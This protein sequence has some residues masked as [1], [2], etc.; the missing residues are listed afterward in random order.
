VSAVPSFVTLA[1]LVPKVWGRDELSCELEAVRRALSL[2]QELAKCAS[3]E[4]MLDAFSIWLEP[5]V[6]HLFLGLMRDSGT[7]A[8]V[9]SS[10]YFKTVGGLEDFAVR[11]RALDL[12][13]DGE[14]IPIEAGMFAMTWSVPAGD[15]AQRIVILR[16]RPLGIRDASIVSHALREMR[17]PLGRAVEFNHLYEQARK[18]SLTGLAN[19]RVLDETL[20][21]VHETARRYERPA[22]LA[23]LDLDNFKKI[24]DVY[25]HEAGDQILS[26]CA[27]AMNQLARS[28]DLI[29]RT[30]GDEFM[31]VLPDTT[32]ANA[33][34]LV[35][36]LRTLIGQLGR[37]YPGVTGFGLSA[38]VAQWSAR[39]SIAEWC[40]RSD[41]ELYV[42][43]RARHRMDTLACT[44]REIRAEVIS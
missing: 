33:L 15:S 30:G 4:A 31:L 19:R 26:K 14:Q 2:N 38:G 16:E 13:G 37:A 5:F 12:P 8:G 20:V 32:A 27:Q 29:A 42:N 36:R 23:S 21:R 1:S 7:S 6:P 35:E 18:D 17:M 39:N 40:R 34:G 28:T 43:K 44:S 24:N 25:G 11:M 22:V 9:I 10:G 41:E 3:V